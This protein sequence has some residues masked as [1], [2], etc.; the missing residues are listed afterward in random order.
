MKYRKPASK[1]LMLLPLIL[2]I[3]SFFTFTLYYYSA[4]HAPYAY[5]DIIIVG[6]IL[7]FIGVIIS[8][9]TRKSRKLYPTLWTSG[10]VICFVFGCRSRLSEKQPEKHKK[11]YLRT[12]RRYAF[13]KRIRQESVWDLHF[14][15]SPLP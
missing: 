14:H 11:T 12:R 5:T 4:N 9:V 13:G 2:G 1:K 7:S 3:S 15:G 8:I 10:L 6:S